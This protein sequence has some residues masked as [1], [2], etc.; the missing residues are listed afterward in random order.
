VT[1]LINPRYDVQMNR[2]VKV[3]NLVM[4]KLDFE[5]SFLYD[6][7]Q[8][9]WLAP[10]KVL[11]EETFKRAKSLGVAFVRI[12]KALDQKDWFFDSRFV[13]EHGSDSEKEEMK[14]LISILHDK[15]RKGELKAM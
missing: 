3:L 1:K 5:Q 11:K 2:R 10:V 14:N 6:E 13:L 8:N 12:S 4:E 7:L 15:K 9:R